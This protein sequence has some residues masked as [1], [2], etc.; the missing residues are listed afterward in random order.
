VSCSSNDNCA[1]VGEYQ[2]NSHDVQGLLLTESSGSWTASTAALPTGA[3]TNPGVSLASVSCAS[4][5]NCT[6]VGA[7]SASSNAEG[8]LL[9]ETS[10]TWGTGVEAGLPSDHATLSGVMLNSVSCASAGNCSAVGTYFDNTANPNGQIVLLD[11]SSGSWGTGVEA[12]LPSQPSSG[13]GFASA[14][15]V[16]CASAGNCS[17]VGTY[18]DGSGI[19]QGLLLTESSGNWQQGAEAGLPGDANT[20]IAGPSP[21]LYSVSCA[22]AG[23]CSA[24]GSYLDSTPQYQGLLLGAQAASPTL[25][26]SAPATGLP[27]TAID[28]SSVSATLA[29]GASPTGTVTFKVFG[30]Q[31]TAPSSCSSG[32]T[33]VGTAIVSDNGTYNPSAGFTPSSVGDYW[34][35]ASYG[36]DTSDNPAASTCGASMAKM[37]VAPL[38]PTAQIS[39]PATGGTYAVD[40]SVATTFSCSEGAGGPGLASCDDNSGTNTVSGGNGHLDTSTTG[41]QQYTVTATSNDTAQDTVSIAYTVAG[42]PTAQISTPAAGGT[43]T[44][45]QSVPT[46]F[47]CSEGASG[48]GIATCADNNGG[49]GTSGHLNTS[50]AGSKTYTVTATSSD[51]QTGSTSIGYTVTNAVPVNSTL[52]TITGSHVQTL[53][54]TEH[55]GT[56]T[57]NPT[58]YA[59]QWERCD[60]NGS[61][62]TAISSATSQKYALVKSDVGHTIR[63]QETASNAAGASSPVSSDATPAVLSINAVCAHIIKQIAQIKKSALELEKSYDS[64]V[65][66]TK[67]IEKR[68]KS[69]STKQQVDSLLTKAAELVKKAKKVLEKKASARA[70][71]AVAA[72]C[73]S[74]SG[75]YNERARVA[76]ARADMAK[77]RVYAAEARVI[78]ATAVV[79]GR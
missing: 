73:P 31:S 27:N 13:P 19:Q 75:F 9:T 14:K 36:G 59:Y 12:T 41:Q 68:V 34:W 28:A 30:P 6:A 24:V 29:N 45:G 11:E 5:G 38:P 66:S 57:N 56:W 72:V 23:N 21:A 76:Q 49:S 55:N 3:D 39:S 71:A 47:S 10:G 48:P 22:S 26:A 42:A 70:P 15:S 51:G 54:L 67:R 78:A 74:E 63:V 1:A 64:I 16:S 20:G 62:C 65:A 4:N 53:T 35:Y 25:T 8:L 77:A 7:Y 2:D 52:P 58:S 17:A 33:T 46:T 79:T 32:G 40:Q 44:V 50:S 61:N 37:V 69:S 60:S 18:L 43:Y